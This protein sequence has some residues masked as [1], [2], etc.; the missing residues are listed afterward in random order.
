MTK[1]LF[2]YSTREKYPS[3]RVDLTELFSNQITQRGY[4]IHWHMQA[5][6]VSTTKNVDI[7][8]YEKFFVGGKGPDR[9]LVAKVK[10]HVKALLHGLRLFRIA[11]NNHYDFVQVRD[12]IITAWIGLRAA[13]R[14]N[15]PFFYWMSFPYPE[16]DIYRSKD[17]TINISKILRLYY[18]LRGKVTKKILYQIVLPKADFIFVQSDKMLQDV[19]REGIDVS[20]MMPI[21]MGINTKSISK[22]NPIPIKD[23]RLQG[24]KV[25]MYLGTMVKVRRIDFLIDMLP[26]ILKRVPNAVLLLVGDAPEQDIKLLK[27]RVSELHLEQH[28]VFTGFVPMEQGWKYIQASDVCLSPFRPSPML[29]STS[30]TKVVEYLA[31]KKPVVANKHPDQSKVLDES[32]AGY[33]VDYTIEAFAEASIKLLENNILAREMGERGYEYVLKNRAYDVIGQKLFSKYE[34]LLKDC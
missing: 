9:G 15:V 21:P 32:N 13:R 25:L 11:S 28:V 33:A 6:E 3:F 31:M 4:G 27:A 26:I 5:M 16:A 22:L 24:K 1:R 23:K 20:N 30:P 14:N 19:A 29:D 34:D 10:N 7:N 8:E 2:L 17:P 12:Q 18:W